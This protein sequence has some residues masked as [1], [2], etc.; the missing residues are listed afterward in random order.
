MIRKTLLE[1]LAELLDQAQTLMDEAVDRADDDDLIHNAI[2]TASDLV[3]DQI[4][5]LDSKPPTVWTQLG[6]IMQDL[7]Q[8]EPDDLDPMDTL[9]ELGII[10]DWM[11]VPGVELLTAI[12]TRFGIKIP[13]ERFDQLTNLHELEQLIIELEIAC[14]NG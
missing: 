13:D 3:H 11:G 2:G 10:D 12:E 7:F 5:L 14:K 6:M 1:R 9:E 8:L 4:V